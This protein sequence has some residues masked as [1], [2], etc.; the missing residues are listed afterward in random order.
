MH[1]P[2]NPDEY[3]AAKARSGITVADIWCAA[4]KITKDQDKSYSS[5]RTTIPDTT[6]ARVRTLVDRV[7][8]LGRVLAEN[9]SM[10]LPDCTVDFND[11]TGAITLTFASTKTIQI[12]C[13]GVD[14]MNLAPVYVAARSTR[15]EATFIFFGDI[16]F[17]KPKY[18]E[19]DHWFLWRGNFP[20]NRNLSRFQNYFNKIDEPLLT[21]AFGA[22]V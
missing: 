17:L 13:T 11:S 18:I 14:M 10:T 4:T 12:D 8:T 6:A 1:Q 16:S 2:M 15:N 5:G 20:E 21:L 19:G 7:S 22:Y 3:R 9:I